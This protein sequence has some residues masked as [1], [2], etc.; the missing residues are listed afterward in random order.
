MKP[1]HVQQEVL[2]FANTTLSQEALCRKNSSNKNNSANEELEEA[3][4]DGLLNELV[5]E[6]MPST[7]NTMMVIWGV[8]VGE[9]YFLIDL[10]NSPGIVEPIYS[11]NP[12]LLSSLINMN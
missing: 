7:R 10:A 8:Y 6:I 3:F 5:P 12:D 1:Q 9:F 2:I 11:I 4:W